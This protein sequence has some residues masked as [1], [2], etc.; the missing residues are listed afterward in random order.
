MFVVSGGCYLWVASF[1]VATLYIATFESSK[2][3]SLSDVKIVGEGDLTIYQYRYDFR[4]PGW[5]PN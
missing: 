3:D 1:P 4:I 5:F 2:A